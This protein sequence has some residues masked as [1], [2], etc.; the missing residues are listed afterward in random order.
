[1]RAV[2]QRV[3]AAKVSVEG[4][5]VGSIGKGW[6]V[7]LGVGKADGQGDV[8]TMVDKIMNTRA[9]SDESGKMNLSLVDTGGSVLLVSQ[10]TL[11]GDCRKGRRPGFTEAAPPETA[12]KLYEQVRDKLIAQNIEVATGT[13]QT[14][15]SVQLTN[16][17]PVTLMID[18]QKN[19]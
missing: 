7:L 3:T 14:H 9:F 15:M 1:M 17:G 2:F 12:V 19:F 18:T 13:F 8:D 16:D 10:F 6:I 4:T 5:T 11:W